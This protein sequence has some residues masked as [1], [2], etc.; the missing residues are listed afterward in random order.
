[1]LLYLD[2]SSLVKLYVEEEDSTEVAHLVISSKVTATSLIAYAESRSAFARRYKEKAFT[3]REYEELITSFNADWENYLILRVQ[4]DLVMKAGDLAEKHGL[5][6]FDAIHLSSALRLKE[7]V[8]EDV[9]FSCS[10]RILEKAA[11]QEG[12][13][14]SAQMQ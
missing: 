5:R 3:R 2:T 11:Q 1:M 13:H 8:S 10:D 4:P 6:G 14:L 9:V 12:L 7:E